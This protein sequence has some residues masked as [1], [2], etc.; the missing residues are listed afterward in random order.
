VVDLYSTV[1]TWKQ[2][3]LPLASSAMLQCHALPCI[4][5]LYFGINRST[6]FATSNRNGLQM[7]LTSLHRWHPKTHRLYCNDLC[8]DRDGQ[9]KLQ[10]HQPGVSSSIFAPLPGLLASGARH[11]PGSSALASSAFG[12]PSSGTSVSTALSKSPT[13]SPLQ[14]LF[15]FA[16]PI[17]SGGISPQEGTV[18]LLPLPAYPSATV[19]IDGFLPP[20]LPPASHPVKTPASCHASVVPS[21]PLAPLDLPGSRTAAV[22]DSTLH[23]GRRPGHT[24]IVTSPLAHF[25]VAGSYTRMKESND[26]LVIPDAPGISLARSGRSSANGQGSSAVNSITTKVVATGR[27]VPDSATGP[28]GHAA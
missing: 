12:N 21:P 16:P 3:S 2:R 15:P 22:L 25:P 20:D 23:Y 28:D 26:K 17:H 10:P 8:R 4:A 11:G 9:T 19:R 24:N 5:M 7:K 27:T 13:S 18:H 1:T 14:S 6:V